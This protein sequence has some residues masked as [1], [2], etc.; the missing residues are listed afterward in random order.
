MSKQILGLGTGA[1]FYLLGGRHPNV[2]PA[3]APACFS[4]SRSH[5]ILTAFVESSAPVAAGA[6]VLL[7]ELSELLDGAKPQKSFSLHS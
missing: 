6:L 5:H 7:M 2:A 1:P 4:D 3:A